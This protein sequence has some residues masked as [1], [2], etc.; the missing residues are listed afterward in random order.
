[1]SVTKPGMSSRMPASMIMTPCASSRLGIAPGVHFA[2][3]RRHDAET[4]DAQQDDAGDARAQ[5]QADRRQH[6]DLAA[7]K[8]EAGDFQ[9][10]KGEQ[11]QR[12]TGNAQIWRRLSV[13]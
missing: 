12:K 9:Q 10:R 11:E 8:D 5:H 3:M 7:D 2:R 1:M 6:A 4:L 13:L